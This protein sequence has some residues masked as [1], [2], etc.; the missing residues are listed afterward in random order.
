[1]GENYVCVCVRGRKKGAHV[2]SRAN[3]IKFTSQFFSF[4]GILLHFILFFCVKQFIILH[5]RN[6]RMRV[7]LQ[8]IY[9]LKSMESNKVE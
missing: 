4:S 3:I 2:G 6:P 8:K 5:L 7:N 9:E 1:M